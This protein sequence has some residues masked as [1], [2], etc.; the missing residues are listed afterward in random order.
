MS[1]NSPINPPIIEWFDH[2]AAS[3]LASFWTCPVRNTRPLYWWHKHARCPF[4]LP[5]CPILSL[6]N[7][8][9]ILSLHTRLT[10]FDQQSNAVTD[11]I[12]KPAS[13]RTIIN[14]TNNPPILE[15]STNHSSL[16]TLKCQPSFCKALVGH[17]GTF[18]KRRMRKALGNH[19]WA[20]SK[21]A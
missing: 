15:F 9:S 19:G 3:V 2:I 12:L 7:C 18:A 5:T 8:Q 11:S 16:K 6:L 17:F 20:L 10:H 13:Q 14:V 1:P 4:Q 21:L